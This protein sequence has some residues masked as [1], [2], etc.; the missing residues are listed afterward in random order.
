MSPFDTLVERRTVLK[1]FLIAGPTF[2]VAAR[3]GLADSVTAF[4]VASDEVPDGADFTD[5][6]VLTHQPT[7]YDILVEVRT[8]GTVYGE[9][10][11]VGMGQCI[12]G[13]FAIYVCVYDVVR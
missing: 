5:T 9:R 3:L 1:G 2:A 8:D 4:P 7:I 6:F 12:I 13:Y 11:T 10:T